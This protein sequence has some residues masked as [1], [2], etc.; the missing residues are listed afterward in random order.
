MARASHLPA[1]MIAA[2]EELARMKKAALMQLAV[3]SEPK[4]A[5]ACFGQLRF[6]RSV[7]RLWIDQYRRDEARLRRFSEWQRQW[8]E[9]RARVQSGTITREERAAFRGAQMRA[10][11]GSIDALKE[12]HRE[13]E[14]KL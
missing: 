2:L 9:Y 10:L 7:K 14:K 5:E 13:L 8:D 6:V 12:R 3:T 1:T 11:K 4:D